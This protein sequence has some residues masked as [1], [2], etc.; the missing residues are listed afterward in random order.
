MTRTA[1]FGSFLTRNGH[2][3]EFSMS[4]FEFWAATRCSGLLFPTT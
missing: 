4:Q 2:W 3:A 1:H